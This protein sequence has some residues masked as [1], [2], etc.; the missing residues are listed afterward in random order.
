MMNTLPGSIRAVT[1]GKVRAWPAR[2]A[3]PPPAGRRGIF[4]LIGLLVAASA[5]GNHALG[6]TT[7]LDVRR[8]ATVM[9]VE[10]VMPSVVNIATTTV[11]RNPYADG[12]DPFY[13][14]Q[15]RSL[16]H[17]LGS[18]VI[19]DETGYLLT[20]DHVVRGVD[21]IF[22]KF[23]TRT[24][25]YEA[26]PVATDPKTDVALLKMKA[27]PGERFQ[28]I[29]LA[30]E[31]DL[32]LGETVLAMGNPFDLGGTVTRGILSSKSR[33]VPKEGQSLNVPNWLQTDAA[34]NPGNSGGPLVN[35][36]GELIGIN[37][38][39]ISQVQ[40]QLAQGIGFAIPISLVMRA[41][42]DI[43]PAEFVK[44]RWFGARIKVGTMPLMVTTVQPGSPADRAG[45][46]VDDVILQVNGDAP[47]SF[48][49]FADL[50]GAGADV[51]L[52]VQRGAE[53]KTIPVALVPEQ[54]VFNAGLVRRRLGLDLNKLPMDSGNAFVIT[55][56]QDASPAA[57]AKLQAGMFITAIDEE[58]PGDITSL[59]KHLYAKK[60]GDPV[61]LDLELRRRAG[62]FNVVQTGA[63]EITPR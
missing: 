27:P 5:G 9:A 62:G 32:L 3:Q 34:I 56:V 39:V 44:G 26:V 38:A 23:S 50:L 31:D 55:K 30:H 19:I 37:V 57:D 42:S 63:V 10:E 13:G 59:A 53:P 36:R 1:K 33:Q 12:W 52:V 8:D 11:V 43:F 15:D 24:N 17:S 61:R 45:V 51:T 29:R 49:D 14:Q 54:S 40:G 60:R 58:L 6:E 7:E 47:K 4:V 18:G 46:K 35:V 41:L 22:V 48:I 25:I 16:Y 20:N 21:Q 28:A 2:F